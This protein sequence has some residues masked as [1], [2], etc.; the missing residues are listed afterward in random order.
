MQNIRPQGPGPCPSGSLSIPRTPQSAWHTVDM[1][2]TSELKELLLLKVILGF[3]LF[4]F[5][6]LRDFNQSLLLSTL[7]RGFFFPS[8][9]RQGC[10]QTSFVWNQNETIGSPQLPLHFSS[11]LLLLGLHSICCSNRLCKAHQQLN[12]KPNYCGWCFAV[13][14]PAPFSAC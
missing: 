3:N 7:Y 13:C 10:T 2:L 14:W 4:S 8:D 1:C 12:N 11:S 9:Y 5:K 6:L